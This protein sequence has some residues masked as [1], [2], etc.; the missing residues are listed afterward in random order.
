MKTNTN[1]KPARK[2]LENVISEQ[3][4]GE[5]QA[6]AL[7]FTAYL[8]VNKMSPVLASVNSWKVNFKGSGVC[9]IKVA[10]GSWLI[11]FHGSFQRDYETTF[12]SDALKKIAWANI[13]H[14]VKCNVNCIAG[15]KWVRASVLGKEFDNVCKNIRIVMANPDAKAVECAKKLVEKTCDDILNGRPVW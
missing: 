13:K 14:C 12:S 15:E 4:K 7:D 11:N 3:I 6:A 10:N 5:T 2:T 8:R 9:Y 1:E